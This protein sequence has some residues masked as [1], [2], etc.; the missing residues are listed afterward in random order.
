MRTILYNFNYYD[1]WYMVLVKFTDL[2]KEEFSVEKHFVSPKY[3]TL[4]TDIVRQKII[5][6]DFKTVYNRHICVFKP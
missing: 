4:G 2:G 5:L 1:S 6:N 3:L